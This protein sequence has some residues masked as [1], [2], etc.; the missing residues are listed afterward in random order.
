MLGGDVIDPLLQGQLPTVEG[1]VGE[2]VHE[3]RVGEAVRGVLPFHR[4]ASTDDVPS[5]GEDVGAET[6]VQDQLEDGLDNVV[7]GTIDFI[8]EED[9]LVEFGLQLGL[10]FGDLVGFLVLAESGQYPDALVGVLDDGRVAFQEFD[11]LL[12]LH[13]RFQGLEESEFPHVLAPR[14]AALRE[15]SG[16]KESGDH[17]FLVG[18]GHASDVGG[19]ALPQPHVREA[20]LVV[21]GG[22]LG[23]LGFTHP[24]MAPEPHGHPSIPAEHDCFFHRLDSHSILHIKRTRVATLCVAALYRVMSRCAAAGNC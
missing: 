12:G 1:Q 5:G 8:Q 16:G 6:A 4:V 11:D 20:H 7:L 13:G 3:G 21:D 18:P 9:A 14:H 23:D 10:E 22:L 19:F 15:V 17:L 2:A 24:P